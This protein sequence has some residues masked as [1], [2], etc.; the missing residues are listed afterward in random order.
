MV[1]L[2]ASLAAWGD[3]SFPRVFKQEV[4]SL[5]TD[6][7][8]L[9][10]GLRQSSHVS[11][12]GF[13]LAIHAIEETSKTIQVRIGVFYSGIIAGCNCSDDPSTVN[14]ETEYCLITAHIDKKTAGTEFTL[15][16]E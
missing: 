13:E 10:A 9:Q 8:P 14:D 15:R 5:E 11:D 2:N 3:E 12:R 7:L 1:Y 4:E 6:Q 16:M